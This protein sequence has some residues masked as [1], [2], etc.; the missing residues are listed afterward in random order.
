MIHKTGHQRNLILPAMA[1]ILSYGIFISWV[2]VTVLPLFWMFYSSFKSNEELT[3]NIYA[4]PQDLF[5]NYND[6]YRVIGPSRNLIYPY[7]PKKDL[8]ERLIIE[9]TSIAPGR[10]LMVFF[11]LKERLPAQIAELKE[12]D[13]VSVSQ[14]PARIRWRINWQTIWFNY[15]S[16]FFRGG[17]FRKFFNS[18]FYSSVSTVLVILLGAMIAFAVSKMN[19]PKISR[20]VLLLIGLGYLISIPSLIIPLFLMLSKIGLTNSYF[21]LLMVYTAIGLPLSVLLM[22]QFMRGLPNSLIESGYIDGANDVLVF[23]AIILPMTV[24]VMITIGIISF[25]GV[26]NEF[27]LVLVLASSETTKS[28]PVGVFSFSSLTSTQLGW[29]LAALVIATLPTMLVYFSFNGHITRGVVAGA[30][31]G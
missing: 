21:G 9:S 5:D 20:I 25:L 16:A 1:K 11:L 22:S 12:G 10:R 7:D 14:L 8:R 30:V 19:F 6:E 31:K 29:Q 18:V 15:R 4:F 24:P 28:L 3:R 13:M 26:W 27:L 23:S 2:L 17:L